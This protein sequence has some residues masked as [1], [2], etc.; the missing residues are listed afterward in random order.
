[1][2]GAGIRYHVHHMQIDLGFFKLVDL[3]IMDN[4]LVKS[5]DT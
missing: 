2:I 1:M 4:L 3:Q 5:K